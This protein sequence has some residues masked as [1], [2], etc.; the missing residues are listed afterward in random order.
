MEGAAGDI[1]QLGRLCSALG[2]GLSSL[3]LSGLNLHQLC[4]RDLIGRIV[5]E[6]A[7]IILDLLICVIPVGKEADRTGLLDR[8]DEALSG[9]FGR[10]L[11]DD[12]H[13]QIERQHH[14]KECGQDHDADPAE[15]LAD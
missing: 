12:E 3:L 14:Q 15:D 5:A 8:A 6:G 9:V 1:D 2:A 13:Q 7:E 11:C 4:I 10:P